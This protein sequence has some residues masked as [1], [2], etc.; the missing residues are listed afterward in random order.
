MT[1]V[2]KRAACVPYALRQGT[3]ALRFNVK[4]YTG[5][6]ATDHPEF[7]EAHQVPMQL[8]ALMTSLSPLLQFKVDLNDASERYFPGLA[9]LTI[10]TARKFTDAPLVNANVRLAGC[11]WKF[12]MHFDSLDQII[13]HHVGTK[14][15]RILDSWYTCVPGDVLFIRAGVWH[16]VENDPDA[17]PCMI[18]NAQ[19]LS[20]R[21]HRLAQRFDAMYPCR[22]VCVQDGKDAL[23]RILG[24]V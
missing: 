24:P 12:P 2:W 19:F 15:W 13:L 3:L 9:E 8:S 11:N 23:H 20:S 18:S 5:D 6:N 1:R 4:V 7:A 10:T 14:R 17:G 22:M 16:S 21:T